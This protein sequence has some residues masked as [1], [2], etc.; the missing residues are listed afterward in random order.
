MM[1]TNESINDPG[2]GND[3]NCVRVAS[4]VYKH[5]T[6]TENQQAST[7]EVQ[8]SLYAVREMDSIYRV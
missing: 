4:I 5:Q 8:T 1:S 7:I 3:G 2:N 6:I